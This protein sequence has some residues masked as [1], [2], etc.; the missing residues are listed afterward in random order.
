M[1]ADPLAKW[2]GRELRLNLDGE[3]LIVKPTMEHYRKLKAMTMNPI[4]R[5]DTEAQTKSAEDMREIFKEILKTTFPD[6][7]YIEDFL[8]RYEIQF[9]IALFV[10][11]GWGTKETFEEL[12]KKAFTQ[13]I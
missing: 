7:Q 4:D 9:Q 8:D 6:S 10:A 1:N 3:I 12:K 13:M 2:C 11:M 5:N